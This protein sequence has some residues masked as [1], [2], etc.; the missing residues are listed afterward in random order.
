MI[1]K[2]VIG[3]VCILGMI[4]VAC[5]ERGLHFCRRLSNKRP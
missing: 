3:W 1:R 5:L 2:F 4:G